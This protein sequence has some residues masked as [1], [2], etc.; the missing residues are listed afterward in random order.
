MTRF[1]AA[2]LAFSWVPFTA[3]A[4]PGPTVAITKLRPQAGLSADVAELLTGA[5]TSSVR[6]RKRFSRVVS[7]TEMAAM[8]DF[9]RQKQLL[10]CSAESCISEIAGALGVDFVL[11]STA[12][13]LG[14]D[15]LID[16]TLLKAR[17]GE[18]VAASSRSVSNIHQAAITAVLDEMVVELLEEAGLATP[19]SA[20]KTRGVK[21]VRVKVEGAGRSWFRPWMAV[22]TGSCC[23][24]LLPPPLLLLS[25]A[26]C[27]ATPIAYGQYTSLFFS[28][29]FSSRAMLWLGLCGGSA[30]A[31]VFFLGLSGLVAIVALLGG[32]ITGVLALVDTVLANITERAEELTEVDEQ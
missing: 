31:S 15:W 13:L 16:L 28:E 14:K 29:S 20:Q 24:A 19:G 3:W 25:A 1:C 21:H 9:E 2:L 18:T 27:V 30:L 6:A 5:L 7:A 4:Q 10:D 26:T 11:L 12:G 23:V 32:G 8:L 17:S 22:G